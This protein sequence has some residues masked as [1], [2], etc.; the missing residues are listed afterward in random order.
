MESPE[1]K[2]QVCAECKKELK[3]GFYFFGGNQSQCFY[4]GEW[5][6][7]DHMAE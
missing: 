7:N 4:T 6:C 5:F 1:G 2:K 3:Q